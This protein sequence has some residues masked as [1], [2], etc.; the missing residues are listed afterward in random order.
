[1][2]SRSQSTS[3]DPI[4]TRYREVAGRV[5]GSSFAKL[6]DARDHPVFQIVDSTPS[7]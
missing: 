7:G 2:P 5:V 3:G 1:M 6:P 4:I